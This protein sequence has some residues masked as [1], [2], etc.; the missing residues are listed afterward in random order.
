MQGNRGAANLRD[1]PV[2]ALVYGQHR[3]AARLPVGRHCYFNRYVRAC[4]RH[5]GCR[6]CSQ[7][8]HVS[9]AAGIGEQAGLHLVVVG[10]GSGN[11]CRPDV[12]TAAGP[13]KCDEVAIHNPAL[14]IQITRAVWA[15][16]RIIPGEVALRIR[17]R[18]GQQHQR[19][20]PPHCATTLNESS[21]KS[22]LNFF[23]SFS[24]SSFPCTP[25][26]NTLTSGRSSVRIASNACRSTAT[27]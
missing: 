7:E 27:Y 25:I 11:G 9:A 5:Y 8:V 4:P 15:C 14:C 23:S 24:I 13:P 18:A 12:G 6:I 21:V 3:G 2:D 22:F 16:P 10:V 19:H 17:R 26:S 1:R 20:A